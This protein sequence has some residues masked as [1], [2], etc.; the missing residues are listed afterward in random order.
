MSHL[1]MD[2]KNQV[3]IAAKGGIEAVVRAMAA[4]R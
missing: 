2:A 4:H 1:A 3:A